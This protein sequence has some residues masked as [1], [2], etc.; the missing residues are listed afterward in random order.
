L[1]VVAQLSID[2]GLQATVFAGIDHGALDPLT[3][4][5]G[6]HNASGRL[7]ICHERA[8]PATCCPPKPSDVFHA[9]IDRSW[10]ITAGVRR[11]W[12]EFDWPGQHHQGRRL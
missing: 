9:D 10:C 6:M 5:R 8:A 7:A 3:T 12:W 2:G 1:Q 4:G 11:F